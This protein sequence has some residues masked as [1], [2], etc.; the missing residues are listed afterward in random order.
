LL[1]HTGALSGRLKFTVRRHKFN[2][3]SLSATLPSPALMQVLLLSDKG[4][5]GGEGLKG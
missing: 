3:D 2:K 1:S 4:E 5:V